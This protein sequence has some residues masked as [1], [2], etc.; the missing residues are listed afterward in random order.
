MTSPA[1]P[2]TPLAQLGEEARYRLLVEAITDYAI[3]M[4]DTEGRVVSWNAGAQRLKG[5]APA[6]VLGQDFSRFYTEAD[7]LAGLPARALVTAATQGR[8]ES[9]GWRLR[10]D[11]SRF[12]ALVV[13]EPIRGEDGS[14]IGYAKVTRDLSERRAA[15][16]SL[17]RSEAQFRMLVQGVTDYAI[18][19]LDTEGLIAS[20]NA[21]AQRIKGYSAAEVVGTH[22][23]RFYRPDDRVRGEP[24]NALATAVRDGRF[25]AEAWRVRKDGSE[26]RAH[27]VID[28]IR[29]DAGRTIG[30]AKVTRDV[31]EKRAAQRAL[32]QARE[33]LF[34]SQKL[35]AIGQLTGGVAHD[36]NNLL[37]VVMSSLSLAKRRLPDDP[38]LV[39][40]I[41]NALDGARRG[42][43]LTQRMLAFARRQDLQP[44]AVHLPTLVDGMAELL[45]RSLGSGVQ[46][47][48]ELPPGL[49]AVRVDANQLELALLNLAVNARDAM[50]D[51]GRLLLQAHEEDVAIDGLLAPGRYVRLAVVDS[52]SGMDAATL[53]RATEPF[54]TTKGAGKGT[55][56]GLAMVHGLAA[57][58]G[59]RFTLQ[60][61]PGQGTTATLWLPVAVE[62]DVAQG[63][64]H[65][66]A[67]PAATRPLRVLAVDDD[68]LVLA[69]TAALL[70]ELG[71]T[72]LQAGSAEEALRM[73]GDDPR[74]DLLVSDHVMPRMTGAQLVAA[75]Q[76]V[77]PQLPVVLATGYAELPA[78]L[79]FSAVRLAKP[80]DQAELAQAIVRA[81]AAG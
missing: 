26:F 43:A 68:A 22:F 7:R 35:D 78:S 3:Y 51:G 23:S 46:V 77:R 79:P 4:L 12:W 50:P 13:I 64:A 69:N 56:L 59:G 39:Q 6:Q 58:S 38:K 24:A 40:M 74:I 27:V 31:T 41:D 47:L 18:Y 49:R 75:A 8:F 61:Q 55:G 67:A 80:F 5:Y 76:Q 65:E 53:A 70:E 42:A 17:R 20:W 1:I 54:F 14:V 37:M 62:G 16:E 73:L 30:F 21:G 15:E 52:G 60:S 71:H 29:D 33:A 25:E 9:E 66:A 57:Q 2:S 10:R 34:Q 81:L 48:T 72:V 63:P 19:M 28:P 44:T 36:F 45:A 32:E 11:G